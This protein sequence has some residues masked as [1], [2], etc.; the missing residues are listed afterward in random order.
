MT[1]GEAQLS[2]WKIIKEMLK[3]IWPRDH[4]KLKARVVIALGLLVGAKVSY[5]ILY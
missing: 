4:P 5:K 1:G 3:H 2:G